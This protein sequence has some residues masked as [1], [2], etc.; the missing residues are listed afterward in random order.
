[1][2]KMIV[3]SLMIVFTLSFTII[4]IN[5]A[6]G[7]DN[8]NMTW[9]TG[10]DSGGDF[11]NSTIVFTPSSTYQAGVV[12]NDTLP[13]Y[14]KLS[15]RYLSTIYY[16]AWA[17]PN[18]YLIEYEPLT[19]MTA[20][21]TVYVGDVLPAN[22]IINET[23]VY[24]DSE[25]EFKLLFKYYTS[26]MVKNLWDLA[27]TSATFNEEAYETIFGRGYNEGFIIGYEQATTEFQDDLID[28][29]NEAYDE[30]IIDGVSDAYE[31]GFDG[32]DNGIG[33]TYTDE[34]SFS[35][36]QGLADA[37]EMADSINIGL[38]GFIPSLLGAVG[39]FFLTI[40]AIEFFGISLNSI[41]VFIFALIGL[42]AIVKLIF[43][44]T[45]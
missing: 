37:P 43:G 21:L 42:I 45:G 27:M 34:G 41:A 10:S 17:F 11:N 9:V 35:Y 29:Q 25:D 12:Y 28:Y 18:E 38:R 26:G 7:Q 6:E 40:G 32:L 36:N 2:K 33:G 1:M 22:L 39:G 13:M 15:Q 24:N 44:G 31:N 4:S 3:L 19:A 23:L 16:Q 20:S 8:L 30:G 5:G 14:I